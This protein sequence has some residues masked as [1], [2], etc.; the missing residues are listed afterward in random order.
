[1]GNKISFKN[2]LNFN[3]MATVIPE[4]ILF[5]MEFPFGFLSGWFVLCSLIFWNDWKNLLIL[6]AIVLSDTYF[7]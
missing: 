4:L 7:T 2:K 5:I 6:F 1:M 3:I